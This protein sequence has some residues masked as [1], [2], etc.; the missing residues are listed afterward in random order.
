MNTLSWPLVS[1]MNW[2]DVPVKWKNETIEVMW[3][4][5]GMRPQTICEI[6]NLGNLAIRRASRIEWDNE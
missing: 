6:I 5:G 2:G 3:T 4:D 1:T